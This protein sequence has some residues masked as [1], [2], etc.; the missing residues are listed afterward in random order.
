M[1][2]FGLSEQTNAQKSRMGF[3]P[4][5]FLLLGNILNDCGLWGR[6]YDLNHAGLH[7]CVNMRKKTIIHWRNP[8]TC[9]SCYQWW[10]HHLLLLT[11][12]ICFS[13][14]VIP[15]QTEATICVFFSHSQVFLSSSV[16]VCDM[17]D[18]LFRVKM[19]RKYIIDK[20]WIEIQMKI[21]CSLLCSVM[22]QY[23]VVF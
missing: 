8:H 21:F 7:N 10:W 5:T 22:Q 18:V 17:W 16:Q 1:R 15:L 19:H 11:T 12:S 13:A 20:S 14:H 6:L 9:A 2:V 4:R 23:D 3:K